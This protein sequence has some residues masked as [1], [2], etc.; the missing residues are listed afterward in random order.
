M[1]SGLGWAGTLG[2]L[3]FTFIHPPTAHLLT[4]LPGLHGGGVQAPEAAERKSH[5]PKNQPGEQEL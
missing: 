4:P 5:S 3:S 1:G 2:T